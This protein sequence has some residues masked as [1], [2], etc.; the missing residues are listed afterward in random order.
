MMEYFQKKQLETPILLIVFNRPDT[1]LKVF[2]S[3]KKIKPKKL[4]I[5]GD[6]P[7]YNNFEDKDKTKQVREICKR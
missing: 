2:D 6:G 5:A 7:R 4:Y 1:T 3:I